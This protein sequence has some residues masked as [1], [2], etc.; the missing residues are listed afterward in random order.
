MIRNIELVTLLQ[1]VV[2]AGQGSFHKAGTLVGVP[3]STISRR[4]RSLE[5]LIGVK[6]FDRHRHGIRPTAAG[7]AFL[8]QIRRIL[9][10]LN[11]VLINAKASPHGKA[12]SLNIGL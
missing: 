11:T 6:L 3:A 12:G 1:T 2:A 10:E 7:D 4:V 9:D 5:E 8:E